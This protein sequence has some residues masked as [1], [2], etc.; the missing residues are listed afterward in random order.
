M[1]SGALPR[2]V[3]V[4]GR[5][6]DQERYVRVHASKTYIDRQMAP[7][8]H[9]R[10]RWLPVDGAHLVDVCER[11]DQQKPE[12][13]NASLIGGCSQTRRL[14]FIFGLGRMA[15]LGSAKSDR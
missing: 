14:V 2:A 8:L 11:L 13:P 3:T 10:I 4:A 9:L 12:N 6:G 15:Q 5:R 1:G 7:Q